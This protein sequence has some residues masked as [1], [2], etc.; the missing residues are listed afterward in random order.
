MAKSTLAVPLTALSILVFSVSVSAETLRCRSVNGNVT[1]AGSGAVS[2]QTVNGH[3]VCVGGGGDVVQSFGGAAE[4]D[5][6][7]QQGLRS[8]NESPDTDDLDEMTAP[9]PPA[10][11]KVPA[12][13][14]PHGHTMSLQRDGHSLHLRTDRLSIDEEW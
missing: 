1:C 6:T 8:G 11:G 9:A 10:D 7:D 3:K 2:C 5:A 13:R 14:S 4:P 12:K